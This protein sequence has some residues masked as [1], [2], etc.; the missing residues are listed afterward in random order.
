MALHQLKLIKSHLVLNYCSMVHNCSDCVV[1]CRQ[2]CCQR[3][4]LT[5]VGIIAIGCHYLVTPV[6]CLPI[7]II[8][9]VLYGACF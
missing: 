2:P 7:F 3:C 1:D 5:V 4:Y 6:S 8:D 9:C